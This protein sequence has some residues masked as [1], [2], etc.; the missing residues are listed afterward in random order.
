M[1]QVWITQPQMGFES[2]CSHWQLK[3]QFIPTTKPSTGAK[4]WFLSILGELFFKE[5]VYTVFTRGRN[6]VNHATTR[7]HPCYLCKYR[8]ALSF[9]QT[10]SFTHTY[11][12]CVYTR[13]MLSEDTQKTV[14]SPD[15]YVCIE[16]SCPTC[17]KTLEMSRTWE[18][19]MNIKGDLRG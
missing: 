19:G 10:H 17:S 15:F 16:H 3:F 9:D 7:I 13:P 8:P 18:S 4:N 6:A 11:I 2:S 1:Q 14:H 12:S 5:C